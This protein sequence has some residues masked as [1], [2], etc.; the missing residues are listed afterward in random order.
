M[1]EEKRSWKLDTYI[2]GVFAILYLGLFL[3][4]CR[5][6]NTYGWLNLSNVLLLVTLGLIW[7]NGLLAAGRWIGEGELLEKL[8]LSRFWLHALFTPLLVLFGWH[9]TCRS[10]AKWA[11]KK[12]VCLL[13]FVLT[14]VLILYELFTVTIGIEL[15]PE[16]RYGVLSYSQEGGTSPPVMVI[17]VSVILLISAITVFRKIKWVWMLVGVILMTAGSMIDIPLPSDA[18]VNAFELILLITLW[19]TKKHLDHHRYQCSFL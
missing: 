11:K 12:S 2:Y 6:A 13:S 18:I 10:G 19:A 16:K 4:G 9:V 14:V 7:D 17:I 15:T 5:L 3:L 1:L 8:N